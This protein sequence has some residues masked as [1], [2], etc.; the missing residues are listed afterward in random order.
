MSK[1]RRVERECKR[2]KLVNKYYFL[3][4]KYKKACKNRTS[5]KE[6]IQIQNER[7]KISRNRSATRVCNR[8]QISGRSRGYYRYF[9]LSRHFLRE[10][11]Y[12]GVLPGVQKSSWL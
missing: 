11:A 9:G 3:C 5:L 2:K 1:K 4:I 7:Q 6:Y 8:C 12:Q 10:I